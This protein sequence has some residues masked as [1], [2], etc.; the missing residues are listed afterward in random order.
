MFVLLVRS[1]GAVCPVYYDDER[2]RGRSTPVSIDFF[3]L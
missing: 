3:A 2:G 1:F